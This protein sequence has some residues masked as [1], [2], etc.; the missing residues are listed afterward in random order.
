MVDEGRKVVAKE[1]A[2]NQQLLETNFKALRSS[3][4]KLESKAQEAIEEELY[5]LSEDYSAMVSGLHL[6]ELVETSHYTVT[7]ELVNI[8]QFYAHQ[9]NPVEISKKKDELF[10][11]R[12]GIDKETEK[13]FAFQQVTATSPDFI[14]YSTMIDP[15]ML[16]VYKGTN[17]R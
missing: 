14:F 1:V 12:D 11:K 4:D 2:A 17:N 5:M 8:S 6:L 7:N 15:F 3:L 16:S 13:A 10:V 9:A